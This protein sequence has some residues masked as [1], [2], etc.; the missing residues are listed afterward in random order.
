[1]RFSKHSSRNRN[2][3]N[4]SNSITALIFDTEPNIEQKNCTGTETHSTHCSLNF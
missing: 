2:G 4:K 3:G 1:M